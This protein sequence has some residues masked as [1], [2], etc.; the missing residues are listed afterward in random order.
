MPTIT[1]NNIALLLSVRETLPRFGIFDVIE[2][3]Y[4]FVDDPDRDREFGPL[5]RIEFYA[6]PGVVDLTFKARITLS[7]DQAD[8]DKTRML[9]LD[10]GTIFQTAPE[11]RQLISDAATELGFNGN[12]V[13]WALFMWFS[14]A[15]EIVPLRM[16]ISPERAVREWIKCQRIV[17]DKLMAQPQKK[18]SAITVKYP[19][20]TYAILKSHEQEMRDVLKY[21]GIEVA[22]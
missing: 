9:D 13:A 10:I 6:T 3:V 2:L 16:T 22:A 8:A 19:L 7:T 15:Q 18:R 11:N 5:K 12:Q 14:S 4:D 21:F 1:D 20:V 17:R